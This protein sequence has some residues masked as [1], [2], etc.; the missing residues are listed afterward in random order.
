M[1]CPER[2]ELVIS[3]SNPNAYL[4]EIKTSGSAGY[5]ICS[6]ED[7]QIMPRTRTLVDTGIMIKIPDGYCGQI[8]PRS[9]FSVKYGIETGA[10]VIDSDYKGVIKV[11]LHN[12]GD[13]VFNYTKGMRI[14]Q[15]LII[16]V[17]TL[18]VAEYTTE[19]FE[20][21]SSDS[22]QRGSGGFGSTG[23]Y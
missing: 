19:T 18:P 21:Y 16:P 23:L 5:D 13:E 9:G 12:H 7:G 17:S 22:N 11:V 10:G 3:K 15:I 20:A 1:I 2:K 4:P 8:W 6:C 14:A